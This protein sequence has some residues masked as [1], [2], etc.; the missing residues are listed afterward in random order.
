MSFMS[1][2][3]YLFAAA[4]FAFV[5]APAVAGEAV[6]P[7]GGRVGLSPIAGLS[8]A[9][10]F[11]GFE[12]SDSRVKVLI[13]E[14]PAAAYGEVESAVATGLDKAGAVKPEPIDTAAGKGFYTAESATLGTETVRRYSMIVP[15]G[16]FSGYV[17]VQVPD[18]SAAY[19]E[20]AVK[21]MLATAVVRKEVP[22]AEQLGAMPFDITELKDFKT[23]R[24]LAPG[25]AV[26]LADN[27]ERSGVEIAPYII[28]GA[29]GT[30]PEKPEDR[31]RFA[32]QAA[33]QIPGL[34][35]GRITSSEPLRIDGSPGFET[36]IEAVNQKDDTPVTLVQWLRF[37][38]AN[39]A[40]R[41][42]ASAPRD[43]WTA[44]FPRFRAVRDGIRAR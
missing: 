11:P 34:R 9:K 29:I 4:V 2:L 25:V 18:K 6:F 5:A 7:P 35:D 30:A 23:V 44:A 17:A 42:I 20:D 33:A 38:S 13:T 22:V 19:S 10:T 31:G 15:G 40:L 24:T 14:L 37:G 28:I 1:R 12:S 27:D 32:Q 16:V 8:V 39:V 36:R 43:Q 26:L 21:T 41:I 3:P